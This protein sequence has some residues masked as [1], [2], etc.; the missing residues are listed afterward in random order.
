MLTRPGV[1]TLA[2]SLGCL[3]IAASLGACD[4]NEGDEDGGD[5]A[6]DVI[7]DAA[8]G[9]DAG[10]EADAAA[11]ADADVSGDAGADAELDATGDA[12]AD[13]AA[14]AEA[15][16]HIGAEAEAD[17]DADAG[18]RA[19]GDADHDA[20]GDAGPD[21]GADA[22]PGTGSEAGAD[23]RADDLSVR[24]VLDE[25]P[26]GPN[27]PD[28]SLPPGVIKLADLGHQGA[29]RVVGILPGR[30]AAH[31]LK[32]W[33]LW[34]RA[35]RSVIRQGVAPSC[36]VSPSL[37]CICSDPRAWCSRAAAFQAGELFVIEEGP[38]FGLYSMTDG[39]RLGSID[40]G[41]SSVGPAVDGSYVWAAS[42]TSL[43]AWSAA[44]ARLLERA[45]DY[46][47]AV[48]VGAAGELRVALGPAGSNVI[49]HVE[50][51]TGTATVGRPFIG[52]FKTWFHDGTHF[53]AA[54][55]P[56]LEIY[57]FDA[58]REE[59]LDEGAS[60]E[61]AGCGDYWWQ[62]WVYVGGSVNR[63]GGGTTPLPGAWQFESCGPSGPLFWRLAED[64][65]VPPTGLLGDSVL[66]A[67]PGPDGFSETS[68]GLPDA[69]VLDVG[70]NETG[71]WAAGTGQGRLFDEGSLTAAGGPHSFGCG[72]VIDATG[73]EDGTAA[74]VV[75]RGRVLL[76][77]HGAGGPRVRGTLETGVCHTH[78]A[79]T[80][81]GATLG[82]LSAGCSEV[83]TADGRFVR[84]RA[85]LRLLALP[86]AAETLS[87]FYDELGERTPSDFAISADATLSAEGQDCCEQRI[88]HLPTK[89]RLYDFFSYTTVL[90][91]IAPS[92]SLVALPYHGVEYPDSISETRR[93]RPAA[94][95]YRDGVLEGT[96]DGFPLLWLDDE[97]LLVQRHDRDGG[98]IETSVC[99]P[100]G[101]VLDTLPLPEVAFAAL[102]PGHPEWL[103]SGSNAAIYDLETGDVLWAS[104]IDEP[105]WATLANDYVVS[106][107]GA[108]LIAEEY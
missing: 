31:D 78:V 5:G 8:S 73:A 42:S 69:D 84:P 70:A 99:G 96:A 91:R 55:G 45:G 100:D 79:L 49:E 22:D 23:V 66:I 14:D 58:T 107:A 40:A 59:L 13:G 98:F 54:T 48:V 27:P 85:R 71:D 39:S 88:V 72:A 95:I 106:V 82:V 34:N 37:R 44:G 103:F 102:V 53:F 16:V 25:Q 10:G 50:L 52:D 61:W 2:S 15:E 87:M 28:T 6:A 11:H 77:E 26:C 90:P 18:P 32:L 104:A 36:V 75:A 94:R 47:H 9:V 97:R 86:G 41:V 56:V 7:P 89:T 60:R 67:S 24:L 43:G 93:R 74:V 38:T 76:L 1:P 33:I 46:S 29:T 64:G 68:I 51:A 83:R 65:E 30:I 3:V 12:D 62:D 63:L 80:P 57:S 108:S 81:D 101:T 105:S 35:D 17:A 4:T 20:V 21:C 19:D 92:G